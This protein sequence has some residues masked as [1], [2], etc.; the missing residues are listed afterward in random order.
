MRGKLFEHPVAD[1]PGRQSRLGSQVHLASHLVA[2]EQGLN[3]D[4][5]VTD[6]CAA[7]PCQTA[8]HCVGQA[9]D[10][11]VLFDDADE[12][13]FARGSAAWYSAVFI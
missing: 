8:G 4:A 10:R 5:E 3:I 1:R 9:A 11:A 2:C 7:V 6:R 12:A 13:G